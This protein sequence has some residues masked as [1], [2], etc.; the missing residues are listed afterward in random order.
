MKQRTAEVLF[1]LV[2]IVSGLAAVL[3]LMALTIGEA[4]ATKP[5]TDQEQHQKQYQNAD[6]SAYARSEND[7]A[8]YNRNQAH[9]EGGDANA[10]GGNSYANGG[11]GGSAVAD[12]GTGI[13]VGQGGDA[14]ANNNLTNNIEGT[15]V[16][17]NSSV[18]VEGDQGDVYDFPSAPAFAPASSSDIEC[19]SIIGFAGQNTS[20][21]VSLGI[22]IPRWLSRKIRDCERE[23]AA[24]G[25]LQM[26]LTLSALQ[27]RCGQKVF[28]D[29]FGT[30][31][32]KC[33]EQLLAQ[34]N[35]QATVEALQE[36]LVSLRLQYDAKST[37]VN[38]VRTRMQ[39]QFDKCVIK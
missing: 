2:L 29:E 25:L 4:H 6:A 1:M 28:Q 18:T 22:P 11:D 33:V 35:C 37:E 30:D 5:K 26:D 38:E 17:D 24:L 20:G 15:T 13:G 9:G 21:G 34:R 27:M 14:A 3:F 36:E 10:T 8:N 12:G 7:N 39:E 23:K 32:A 31:P 19:R 16:N